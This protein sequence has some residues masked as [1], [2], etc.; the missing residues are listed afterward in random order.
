MQNYTSPRNIAIYGHESAGPEK[1]AEALGAK[2][3]PEISSEFEC[4]IFVINPNT[5]IDSDTI[6][7]WQSLDDF[8][9]PRMVVVTEL[10]SGLGD[11]DDAV[12]LA[13]RTLD[14]VVTPY[15]VLHAED[16]LPC[17]LI[18]L[19][20]MTIIDYSTKPEVRR[21]C[22]AEHETLVQEFRAEYIELATSFGEGAFA[23]GVLFPAIPLWIEK[24]IGIKEVNEYLN[25]LSN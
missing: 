21:A 11:F 4:A 2:F 19:I 8:L 25:Q 14:Q 16:G 17:A 18:S 3:A 13:T 7:T 22:E 9:T 12:M 5:G 1:V 10:Q 23:A 15:L 6:S 20:D 24:G